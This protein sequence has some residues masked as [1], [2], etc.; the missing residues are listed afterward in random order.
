MIIKNKSGVVILDPPA[1]DESDRIRSIMNENSVTLKYSLTEHISLPIGSYIEFQGE[2][3]TL[4]LPEN[5]KKHGTRNFEYTVT[6]GSQQEALKK[7]KYKNTASK[8]YELKFTL[9]AKPKMFLDLLVS[10]LN[11][12]DSGWTVGKHI[13]ATEKTLSFNHEDCYS[14]LGKLAQEFNTEWEVVGKTIHL[15][16]VEKFKTE[17]LALSYGRGNGFKV[18]VG[19]QNDGDKQPLTLLY[20]QGGE[21]NIDYSTYKGKTLLL[22]KSQELEYEG[23]FY[24]TD[25]DGMYITRTE[26]PTDIVEDSFDGSSIYPMR[27]G[28]ISGVDVII[29]N[30]GKED[31]FTV[32]DIVDA[33][34]PNELNFEKCLIA[35]Q[36]MTIIF[37]TG[38][39]AGREF[40]AKYIH[41][42]K[43]FEIVSSE[44]DGMTL[45]NDA[46]KPTIGDKYAVFNISLPSA[47]V[48]NNTNKTGA[49][50]DMFREAV[51][52]FYDNEVERFSFTGELDP[53]WAR[54]NWLAIGGKLVPG[55]YVQFSDTQ[56]Q[57]E[58]ILIRIMSVRDY[59]NKPQS[60]KLELSNAPVSR[61]VYD[62]IG[63]IEENEEV[64]DNSM[65]ELKLFTQR[66]FRDAQE[67]QK[68]L[69]AAFSN[70]S[71]G[72]NPIWIQTMSLLV[73]DESLQ[74]R[75]VNSKTTPQSVDQYFGY[76]KG[77]KV[78]SAGSGIIQHM[79]LGIKSLSSS[80]AADQYK[81]WDIASYVSP[82]LVDFPAMYLYAKCLKSGTTGTFELSET[83]KSFEE[84]GFYYFL[85]GTL[86]TES[87]GE[88]SYVSL[89][90][91][92]EVLP[93]RITTDRV[94]SADGLNFLD[95]INNSFRVGDDK[96]FLEFNTRG[97][98]KLRLKGT[99]IQSESGDEN[100]IGV[101]RGVY[102]SI[103]TYFKA[104][105]V[106]YAVNGKTSTYRF[107]YSTSSKGIAP[108]N[109]TYWQI[110]ASSG[111]D[112]SDGADGVPG[113]DGAD[114]K[115][116]YTWIRY[117]D[118]AQGGG[119]SNSPTNKAY[120]GFAYNKTTATES[121]IAADYSWSKI[122]GENGTQG[123]PGGTGADGKTYYT[124]IAYSPNSNGSS[125]TQIPNAATKYIGISTN[126]PTATE[127]SNAKDYV[128]SL[129]KGSDGSDG[130]D[131][132]P[133]TI[134]PALTYRGIYDGSKTYYGNST[135][136]D[137][138]KYNNTYYV[139]RVDAN[140]ISNIIPTDTSKWKSFGAH[141]ESIATELLLAEGADIA[142]LVFRNGRLESQNGSIF[143][144]GNTGEVRLAGT[145]QYS[146]GYSG[147]YSDVNVF[148]I[149]KTTSQKYITMG[150]EKSDI[151]KVCRLFNSNDYGGHDCIVSLATF[152]IDVNTTD[153]TFGTTNARLSPQE[154]LEVTC[155]EMPPNSLGSYPICAKW[156]ITGRFGVDN[157]KQSQA[158]GRFPRMLAMGRIS[159]TSNSVSIS[160]DLYDGRALSSVF[161]TSRKGVGF[162]RIGFAS[163]VLPLGYKLMLCGY[164]S[165]PL[166]GTANNYTST[167]FDIYTSDDSSLNDGSVEIFIFAP[168]WEYNL[169]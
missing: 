113:T 102:N 65:K 45:P 135:R 3:Y 99:I 160:G 163:G 31:E 168:D 121:N 81:F 61:S 69:E 96:T 67:T 152:G 157:F 138:V 92:T 78:F 4:W 12:H 119:I 115:T 54:E 94:V 104:D 2:R 111:S 60:P 105:E 36:S 161:T 52:Y 14:I 35:G 71:D 136:V 120:I 153:A 13:E 124:W 132:V 33:S 97:D 22:P 106:T 125:M 91:F 140:S 134:G 5:F 107:I 116:Y 148:Y 88:R 10:N 7:S 21:R 100:P 77:T 167:Y 64:V 142:G 19:R 20:V 139:A 145:M 137:A 93:G 16:K 32:Y 49:S 162:Y 15:R 95:F 109:T 146:T 34:I 164:S 46:L 122:K 41:T 127:S 44:M 26:S 130:A 39:L 48:C 82:P 28:T 68:M 17:P 112:G 110:I 27:E 47:Y 101:F 1:S 126:R 30:E 90:G 29:K 66:R 80:H 18:G 42:H 103:H 165:V 63:K 150:S 117:A 25:A 55:G 128:W 75:F 59:I 84:G 57:T 79:T 9:T 149:P 8:P 73:G 147:N 38:N 158:K 53:K 131:G 37:Q 50:W 23:N 70:F 51:R 108:T 114:G 72:V 87:E 151:G 83:P 123:I 43:R 144:D 154:A 85:V 143:I 118:T 56:F 89:Y 155:F 156:S 169:D 76:D 58:G 74:I 6:F 141:F 62:E 40:E 133:G 11:L 159:G 86:G 166:K 129:F 24:K 98:G